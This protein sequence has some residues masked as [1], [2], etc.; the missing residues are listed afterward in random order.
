MKAISIITAAGLGLRIKEYSFNKYGKYVDKPLVEFKNKT[1]L[2]WSLKPL[3]P[4]ITNGILEFSDIYI[5]IREEQD[6]EAFRKECS[7]INRLINIICIKKLS[8]GPAHTAFEALKK[9]F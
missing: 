9:I 5:V 6:I 7:K 3:Y 2:E 4:L 1:L 8:K